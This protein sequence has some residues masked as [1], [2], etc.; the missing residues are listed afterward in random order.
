MNYKMTY[1]KNTGPAPLANVS[2]VS[3]FANV[4]K[5]VFDYAFSVRIEK[6]A[7]ERKHQI[8]S[9][10]TIHNSQLNAIYLDDLVCKDWQQLKCLELT[11]AKRP[12]LGLFK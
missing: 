3:G 8:V 2:H 11:T 4:V 9:S 12:D 6:R 1:P 10:L 5:P 7:T